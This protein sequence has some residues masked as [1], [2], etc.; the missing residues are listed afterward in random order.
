[1]NIAAA[2]LEALDHFHA[3]LS[4]ADQIRLRVSN[5]SWELAAA[6]SAAGEVTDRKTSPIEKARKHMRVARFVWPRLVALGPDQAVLDRLAADGRA[7][8]AAVAAAEVKVAE[9]LASREARA[10]ERA[11]E[12]LRKAKV[13][14]AK[15]MA[16]MGTGAAARFVAA[17]LVARGLVAD[18]VAG[19]RALV[20]AVAPKP[21]TDCTPE[22]ILAVWM[23]LDPP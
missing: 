11:A 2:A 4:I 19:V 6:V 18:D 22:E 12:A 17:Q 5:I 23:R 8:A 9:V 10:A 20:A 7:A 3:P 14:R 16:G 15:Q 21:P 13:A 1:M